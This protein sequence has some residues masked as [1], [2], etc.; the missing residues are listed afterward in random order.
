[1]F[2]GIVADILSRILGKYVENFNKEQLSIG[3]FGGNVSLKNLRLK[4]EALADL[5]LPI[6]VIRGVLGSLE[7]QVPWKNLSSK[8][9]IVK[10]DDIYIL[11]GPQKKFYV[12]NFFYFKHYILN[13]FKTP[14]F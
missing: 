3:I 14:F 5:N 2:E 12:K 13:L 8:P 7:L 10:V 11:C 6:T 4:G 9:V 1:M